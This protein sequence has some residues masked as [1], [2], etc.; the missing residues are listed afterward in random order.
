MAP[1]ATAIR[2]STSLV[3]SPLPTRTGRDVPARRFSTS[4]VDVPSPVLD[5]VAIT[6]S[7]AK[8]SASRACSLTGLSATIEWLPCFT[9]TSASTAT[10]RAWMFCRNRRAFAAAPSTRPSL[11][12]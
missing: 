12:M 3:L 8:N 6:A 7:A 2:G 1:S 11:A 5:P 4:S 10:C 9:W